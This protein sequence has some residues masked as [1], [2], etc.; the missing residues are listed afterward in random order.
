MERLENGRAKKK[1]GRGERTAGRKDMGQGDSGTP[2]A[3]K[4]N[5][6]FFRAFHWEKEKEKVQRK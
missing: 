1:I 3:G 2:E 6:I 5:T 4:K